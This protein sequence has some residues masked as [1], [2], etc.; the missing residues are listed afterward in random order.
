MRPSPA[1]TASSTAATEAGKTC[2]SFETAISWNQKGPAEPQGTQGP[3]GDQGEQG[4]MGATGPKGDKG[5]QGEQGPMGA[6]GPKGDKGDPGSQGPPGTSGR[7]RR[8]RRSRPAWSRTRGGVSG[9][10]M[11]F[12]GVAVPPRDFERG[13]VMCPPGKRPLGGGALSQ[14]LTLTLESAVDASGRKV[15]T[16]AFGPVGAFNPNDVNGWQA[17]AFN[18]DFFTGCGPHSAM[19]A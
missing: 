4:S 13:T 15:G 11:V 17:D 3:K 10:E 18:G 1:P 12:R 6:T 14:D 7:E 2:L 5:D 9:Y 19:A 16:P 8:A